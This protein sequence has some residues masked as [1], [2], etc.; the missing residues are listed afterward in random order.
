MFVLKRT[1]LPRKCRH[2]CSHDRYFDQVLLIMLPKPNAQRHNI[3]LYIYISSDRISE[4]HSRGFHSGVIKFV[5]RSNLYVMQC[6]SWV[7]FLPQY[8]SLKY[9]AGSA[10]SAPRGNKANTSAIVEP[11]R[12]TPLRAFTISCPENHRQ[13]EGYQLRFSAL[14]FC[15]NHPI[16]FEEQFKT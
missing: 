6:T 3:Y 14:A 2:Y 1:C 15:N 9:S 4:K 7:K 11:S 13:I 16:C 10:P 5:R 12:P 8:C